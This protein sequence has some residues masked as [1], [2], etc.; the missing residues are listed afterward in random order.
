MRASLYQYGN[1][2]R[3]RRHNLNMTLQEV[4]DAIGCCVSAVCSWEL[5]QRMPD[6]IH[7]KALAGAPFYLRSNIGVIPKWDVVLKR[8]YE[9][10]RKAGN[11]SL[12]ID[13]E[14]RRIEMG[15]SRQEVS[16]ALGLKDVYVYRKFIEYGVRNQTAGV[17]SNEMA[18]GIKRIF[19]I[20]CEPAS[21]E[22][23]RRSQIRKIPTNWRNCTEGLRFR[24][25]RLAMGLSQRQVAYE[26]GFEASFLNKYELTRGREAKFPAFSIKCF[27]DV[28][29]IDRAILLN[30]ETPD[31]LREYY[32]SNDYSRR[33]SQAK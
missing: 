30:N 4:A 22:R 31:W 28:L 23:S 32:E 9:K 17:K 7:R 3:E 24:K 1:V 29:G 16:D 21:R 25:I 13:I 14:L 33:I 6:E 26:A 5:G 19:G 12:C 27:C 10:M 15:M 18:V 2:L 8:R 20:D 11:P